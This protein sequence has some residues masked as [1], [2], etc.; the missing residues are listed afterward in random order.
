M[1]K[2][3]NI[4]RAERLGYSHKRFDLDETS[5]DL[6]TFYSDSLRL[7]ADTSSKGMYVDLYLVDE[8]DVNKKNRPRVVA[9]FLFNR[10]KSPTKG[11]P[12]YSSYY[13]RIDYKY[14]G[15]DLAP[16]M[17]KHLLTK[18]PG[19]ILKAG[20]TQSPGG[21][22]IW[23]RLSKSKAVE[24]FALNNK[25]GVSYQCS[26]SKD[27]GE[28]DCPVEVYDTNEFHLYAIRKQNNDRRSKNGVLD[29]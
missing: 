10:H 5:I 21:K 23:N 26:Y 22:S 9:N 4:G 14:A 18:F 15:F 28:V 17:Y 3:I 19:W 12:T 6:G 2:S 29:C 20:G 7:Y 16:K 24:V 1:I 13:T 25:T 11:V 8:R 27:L